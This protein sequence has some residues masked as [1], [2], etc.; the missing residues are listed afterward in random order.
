MA[1]GVVERCMCGLVLAAMVALLLLLRPASCLPLQLH[2]TTVDTIEVDWI[3]SAVTTGC[4]GHSA[5]MAHTVATRVRML[6]N[7]PVAGVVKVDDGVGVDSVLS[8]SCSAKGGGGRGAATPTVLLSPGTNTSH[9]AA[10]VHSNNVVS[11]MTKRRFDRLFAAA[12]AAAGISS[13][14][15]GD[16]D[17][18]TNWSARSALQSTFHVVNGFGDVRRQ[19]PPHELVVYV[20]GWLADD[21]TH[22]QPSAGS[23]SQ[24]GAGMTPGQPPRKQPPPPPLLQQRTSSNYSGTA[25]ELLRLHSAIAWSASGSGGGVGGGNGRGGDDA[26]TTTCS[27]SL[28]HSP[29]ALWSRTLG[30]SAS[31]SR[32][33]GPSRE[34][35]RQAVSFVV[36]PLP[37]LPVAQQ[38]HHQPPAP[39]RRRFFTAAE[40]AVRPSTTPSAAGG[41]GGSGSD[42]DGD[43]DDGDGHDGHDGDGHDGDG[44]RGLVSTVELPHGACVFLEEADDALSSGSIGGGAFSEK[45]AAARTEARMEAVDKQRAT[46]MARLVERAMNG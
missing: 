21:A 24:G 30:P 40:A 5:T 28:V 20:V 46:A 4:G 43:D 15:A 33:S 25:T 45:L 35:P 14:G 41:D 29:S 16:G 27:V 9:S 1:A 8:L 7:Q 32:L 2:R 39:K 26:T 22:G 31:T 18:D 17:G 38:H 23:D 44:G 12:A 36:P 6:F 11:A 3:E 37:P 42:D 34:G 13:S 10:F 19:P